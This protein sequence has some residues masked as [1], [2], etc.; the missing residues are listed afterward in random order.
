MGDIQNN[1]NPLSV[2][3][4]EQLLQRV[5]S[6]PYLNAAPLV[7]GLEGRIRM[8]PPSHLARELRSGV[9]DAGLVSITEVLFHDA[10]DLLDGLG[11]ASDG[12][13]Y[14]VFLAHRVPLEAIRTVRCDTASLTSV[15]LLRVL[16]AERGIRPEFEPLRQVGDAAEEEAVL[17]IGD[18]A[19]AFRKENH[20]HSIWDLGL[21]WKTM[22]GNSFVFAAWALRRAA[23]TKAIRRE[24]MLAGERG[25]RNLQ[26]VIRDARGFDEAF[27]REYL[28][29][30][31]HHELTVS[32]KAGVTHFVE[33]LRRH[34]SQPVYGPRWV[35]V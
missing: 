13:V 22:T 1:G 20:D 30:Y 10:Y 4:L 5:G 16:L 27:R 29:R 3:E 17:L 25:Q 8:L 7:C 24:L 2:E 9:L 21:A 34:G 26:A 35:S 19:I 12:E 28:T 23:D 14:S 32:D 6:V 15:N 11:V 18:Q 33:L 31:T